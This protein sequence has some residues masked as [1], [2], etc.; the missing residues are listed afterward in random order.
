[1]A[2]CVCCGSLVQT[3]IGNTYFLVSQL[4]CKRAWCFAYSGNDDALP[5]CS[6]RE[7]FTNIHCHCCYWQT[8]VIDNNN[9]HSMWPTKTIKFWSEIYIYIYIYNFSMRSKWL[10]MWKILT[11]TL[12]QYVSTF[13][14]Y[15][16]MIYVINVPPFSPHFT[17][18]SWIYYHLLC[19]CWSQQPVFQT[20]QSP[21]REQL[22]QSVQSCPADLLTD[23]RQMNA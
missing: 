16:I 7:I 4:S 22:K 15:G 17:H 20:G 8:S 18:S 9:W 6:P 2:E 5:T 1:M 13:Q 11:L 10:G 21:A 19:M 3:L 14:Q 23:L 12:L